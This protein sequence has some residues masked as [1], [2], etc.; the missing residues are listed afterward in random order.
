[1]Q[2]K[3]NDIKLLIYGKVN[4]Q[5][6]QLCL[7]NLLEKSSSRMLHKTCKKE[8]SCDTG[9]INVCLVC[10]LPIRHVIFVYQ[11]QS[12]ILYLQDRYL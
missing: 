12:L 6:I 10:T 8:A 5:L 2:T 9:Y 11:S 4:N 7:I 3:V 1:M